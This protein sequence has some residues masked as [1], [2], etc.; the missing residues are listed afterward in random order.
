MPSSLGKSWGA[1][2]G[3]RTIRFR[4]ITLVLLILAPFLGV[5]AW[6]AFNLATARMA[7]IELSRS[8]SAENIMAQT[9][10]EVAHSLGMLTGLGASGAPNAGNFDDF[11]QQTRALLT[12]PELQRIWVFDRQGKILVTG[13]GSPGADEAAMTGSDLISRIF[14]GRQVVSTVR[15]EGLDDATLVISVPISEGGQVVAGLAAEVRARLLERILPEAG[16][17]PGWVAAVVDRTG[18]FVMRSLDAEGRVGHMARPELKA[19]A[20]KREGSGTFEN[21][22]WEGVPMLNSFRRSSLTDWTTVVAVPKA[23]VEAPLK[24]NAAW[25]LIG[26]AGALMLSLAIAFAY[27]NRISEPIRSLGQMATAFAKGQS[28]RQT[29]YPLAELDEVRHAF[30]AAA[31]ESAHLSALVASSGDA[32]MSM[33]LDGTIRTWNPA[34]E[35][36]FG[37]TAE[38]IVGKPKS[39]LVPAEAIEE[40]QKQLA[41]VLAGENVRSETV[42]RHRDGTRIAVSVEAAPIRRPDGKIIATSSI[43]HD[44]TDRRANEEHRLFLTREIAHRSKNQLAIIQSIAT[45]TART[46]GSTDA[47]LKTFR[48]R[49]QGLSASHDL[50]LQQDWRGAPIEELVRSQIEIF[51]GENSNAIE[52]TGPPAMLTAAAAEAIGLAIHELATNSAKYGALSVASGRV[53]VAWEQVERADGE[54]SAGWKL[55]WRERG[56]PTV[57]P[58][59]DSGFGTQV[60]K[61]TVA[62]AVQGKAEVEY[63]PSGLIWT[64]SFPVAAMR[65]LP[66]ERTT[67]GAEHARQPWRV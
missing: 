42:R 5:F 33:N 60:I 22:T 24:R 18:R 1:D 41:T 51:V 64:L 13:D 46:T 40:F 3:L 58:P 14:A 55:T 8:D 47:F 53:A 35:I 45:Q 49:L 11:R 32:I 66:Q 25:V 48:S 9:D 20:N 63:L 44:I 10:R 56:G 59:V 19:A 21:V 15:G 16:L 4:I 57:T 67:V 61:R 36:L 37:Y 28:F 54:P 6:M 34:A 50:L 39:V 30:E 38:E 26:G 7:L 12:R 17:E 31:V 23:I 27:A 29:R 43:L 52:I 62:M 65:L 2:R